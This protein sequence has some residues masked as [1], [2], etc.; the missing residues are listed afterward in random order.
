MLE[1]FTLIL[2][3]TIIFSI[4]FAR[5]AYGYRMVAFRPREQQEKFYKVNWIISLLSISIGFLLVVFLKDYSAWSLFDLVLFSS[6]VPVVIL[7]LKSYKVKE[8]PFNVSLSANRVANFF[9]LIIPIHCFYVMVLIQL[10]GIFA[11]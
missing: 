4:G 11:N 6:C 5:G 2:F 8:W 3:I 10:F 1:L 9:Y 7:L